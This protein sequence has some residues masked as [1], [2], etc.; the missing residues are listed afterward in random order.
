MNL[1]Q[2][3]AKP[4]FH[5]PNSTE[6]NLVH[7]GETTYR[8]DE[9]PRILLSCFR[10]RNSQHHHKM[11]SVRGRPPLFQ[12]WNLTTNRPIRRISRPRRPQR[13]RL[14]RRRRR[15]KRALSSGRCAAERTTDWALAPHSWP[16]GGILR[17]RNVEL[18]F[19]HLM[20]GIQ[21]GVSYLSQDFVMFFHASCEGLPGQ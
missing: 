4:V 3:R 14:R 18:G 12:R 1:V 16:R 19:V 17:R 5:G 21:I 13:P 11:P 8:L 9:C 2:G 6:S 20:Y 7:H 10:A 15:S